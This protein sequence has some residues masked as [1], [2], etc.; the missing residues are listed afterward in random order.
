MRRF[1]CIALPEICIEIAEDGDRPD[2]N[3]S[4]PLAVVVARRGRGGGAGSID[5]E[6]DL[7]GGTR[8][9]SVSRDARRLG[10]R[11]G[12]TMA[13]ARSRCSSLRVRVVH[14]DAIRAALARIAEVAMAFGPAVAFDAQQ[15]VV[16][17]EISGCAHL[18]GGERELAR[19]IDSSIRALGH[20]P[21]IAIAEGPRIAAAVA[22]C[23]PN[24]S[25]LI[26]PEGEGA[27][28]VRSLPIVALG[29]DEDVREWL[30]DLG[31]RTCGDLQ[32]LPRRALGIRL[33]DRALDVLQMLGGEDRSPLDAWRPPAVPEERIELEWGVSSSDTLAFVAKTLCD[34]LC[35]RLEGRAM[36][37]ARIELVLA[38]DRALCGDASP[39]ATLEMAFPAPVARADEMHAVVRARLER[40]RLAAP[41]LSATLRAP[42]LERI[43]SQSL[44]LLTPEPKAARALPRLVAE[45]AAYLGPANVGTLELVDTW[46]PSE[47][48]RLVPFGAPPGAN[49]VADHP[50]VTSALEPS[51]LVHPFRVAARWL[52]SVELLARVES[53]EWW[54]RGVSRLDMSAAWTV[55]GESE[56]SAA[57][58]ADESCENGR[59]GTL[60]LR[61]DCCPLLPADGRTGPLE[62][63][64]HALAWVELASQPD[65]ADQ[66]A[67]VHVAI[68]GWID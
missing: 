43:S 50:L 62:T 38:L 34:R 37:A 39:S 14:E 22:R 44:D 9:D 4:C 17:V 26:V 57:S 2:L 64:T 15:N 52:D 28:A 30:S 63:S 60:Q 61:A 29:L 46:V 65:K 10:V 23:L 6:R 53:V 18:L 1:A 35:A 7:Q 42:V 48:T 24:A 51:R 58:I 32:K 68:R 20:S 49:R 66:P 11:I 47:R 45:L 67:R 31:F 55:V 36:A 25:P 21:R 5:T 27:T 59:I 33:G 41:V 8:L 13:T 19:A 54:R 40:E 16:W 3:P 12:Q 56:R